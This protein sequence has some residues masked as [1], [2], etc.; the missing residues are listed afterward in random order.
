VYIIDSKRIILTFCPRFKTMEH[1]IYH[2]SCVRS[3]RGL[4]R[5]LQVNY[6]L[7]GAWI[8]I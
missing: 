6:G 7:G 1:P 4:H 8:G 3:E 5:R 2:R